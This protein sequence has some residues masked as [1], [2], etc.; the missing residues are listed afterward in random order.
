MERFNNWKMPLFDD[1]E[2]ACKRETETTLWYSHDIPTER[3]GW[4]CQYH[5]N[6]KLG[7]LTDIGF[8]TY[9]NAHYGVEIKD[10]VQI[11]SHCSIYSD[12]TENDT[13]GPVIIGENSLIGS[14]CLILPNAVIPPNSKIKA[15][16]IVK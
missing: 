6:L 8:G 5:E 12:N 15:Y 13:H 11:G 7:K 9:I 14:F 1:E 4:K 10:E 16:S 3:Y 2:Y